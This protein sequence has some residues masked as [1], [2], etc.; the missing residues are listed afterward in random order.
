MRKSAEHLH[1]AQR[2][3]FLCRCRLGLVDYFSPANGLHYFDT[4]NIGGSSV[5]EIFIKADKVCKTS[6]LDDATFVFSPAEFCSMKS[7]RLQSIKRRYALLFSQENTGRRPS[8]HSMMD[9]LD[10]CRASNRGI[11]M[12]PERQT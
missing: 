11:D 1:D 2:F 7:V 4:T 6:R 5:N 12:K 10:D 3:S 9:I 8:V